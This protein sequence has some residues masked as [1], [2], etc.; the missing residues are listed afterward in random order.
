M[1]SK[2]EISIES[3]SALLQRTLN[4]AQRQLAAADRPGAKIAVFCRID[5][6]GKTLRARIWSR[7]TWTPERYEGNPTY[8]GAYDVADLIARNSI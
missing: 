5:G 8:L 4:R 3:D 6:R 7:V 2:V 1:A